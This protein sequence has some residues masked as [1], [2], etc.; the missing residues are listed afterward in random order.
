VVDVEHWH[1]TEPEVFQQYE[2]VVEHWHGTEPEVFQ[3][4]ER[5][6]GEHWMEPELNRTGVSLNRLKVEERTLARNRT[7]GVTESRS[8]LQH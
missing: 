1:G 4:Y 7:R 3:Q 2:Q 8:S 5:V 6:D